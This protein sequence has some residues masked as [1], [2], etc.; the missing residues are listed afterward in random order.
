MTTSIVLQ[1]EIEVERS[2]SDVIEHVVSGV[3]SHGVLGRGMEIRDR[4]ADQ[5]QAFNPVAGPL[6]A[7]VQELI[8]RFEANPEGSTK[9][10]YTLTLTRALPLRAGLSVLAGLVVAVSSGALFRGPIWIF[11]LAGLTVGLLGGILELRRVRHRLV[12]SWEAF[13]KN[14]EYQRFR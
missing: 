14:L 5:L 8:V 3:G 1:G 10:R 13:L 7:P 4:T 9:V 6:W 2:L 12:R 11:G